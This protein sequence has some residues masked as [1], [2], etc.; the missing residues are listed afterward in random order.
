MIAFLVLGSVIL[1]VVLAIGVL[2][3][4]IRRRRARRGAGLG[5]DGVPLVAKADASPTAPPSDKYQELDE[6]APAA[7]DAAA[8]TQNVAL[9]DSGED[10]ADEDEDAPDMM[11]GLTLEV[12]TPSPAPLSKTAERARRLKEKMANAA[13][14]MPS[15]HAGTK[16]GGTERL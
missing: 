5:E 4:L 13:D 2:V 7:V 3:Y 15:P 6:F 10:F 16:G 14:L 9:Q 11:D 12:S 1:V 8:A